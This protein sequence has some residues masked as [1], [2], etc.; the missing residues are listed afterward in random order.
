MMGCSG[1]SPGIQA[2][3]NVNLDSVLAFPAQAD[4]TEK[5]LMTRSSRFAV[6]ALGLMLAGSAFAQSQTTPTPGAPG[7][8]LHPMHAPD[9]QQQ[10]QHLT[11]QL[12]LT[13]DQQAK[14]GPILQQRAQQMQALRADNSLKPADRKTKAMSLMQD[15]TQQIEAVLTPAQRDQWKAMRERAMEHAQEMR[16]QKVPSS[17]SSTG[18]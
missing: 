6:L 2:G 7:P 17:S 8:M 1:R 11:K 13:A 10:L 3:A 5:T 18:K 15:T 4:S 16:E 9:P 12:Q 14:I